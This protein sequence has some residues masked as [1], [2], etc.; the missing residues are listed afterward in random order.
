[1]SIVF[2]RVVNIGLHG[3][4]MLSRFLLIFFLA[5][6]LSP[7]DV[8][9]YGLFVAAV[10]Y[11]IYFVGL[12]FYTYVTREMIRSAPH[13]RAALLKSQVVLAV[14]LYIFFLPLIY[15]LLY[16]YAVWPADLFYFFLPLLFLEHVNQEV[17]R[18]LIA[19][20]QQVTASIVLFLRQGSWAIVA[21]FFMY[22]YNDTRQL[23]V[24]FTLWACAGVLAALL[25]IRKLKGLILGGWA[26]PIDWKWIR[27]GVVVSAA[28]LLATLALRGIQTFDR[29]WVE[30]IGGLDV[31]AAYVLFLSVSG[32]LLAFLDAGIFSF[33]YPKL[34]KLNKNKEFALFSEKVKQTLLFTIALSVLFAVLSWL[35]LPVLLQWID[36]ET[37]VAAISFYPWLL[38]ATILNAIGLVPHFAL[39][40][41]GCD[42]PIIYS[43]IAGFIAFFISGLALTRFNGALAIPQSLSIAFFVILVWKIRSYRQYSSIIRDQRTKL[44]LN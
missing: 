11:S 21:L 25:G 12:D 33:S 26:D 16:L 36:K 37:Y 38:L 24:I 34:I 5:K 30:S 13:K 8:G 29:Y 1:M 23:S 43:H 18:I 15:A 6:F 41:S 32:S 27:R 10:G 20:S 17:S 44:P 19:L 35:L 39:Y 4:N 40:A 28:F 14:Y 2:V 31:V 3:A 9:Y 22:F 7:S 42:R